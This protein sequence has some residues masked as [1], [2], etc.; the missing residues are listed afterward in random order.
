MGWWF[1][2]DD[3]VYDFLR[4]QAAK[5]VTNTE[6]IAWLT[7]FMDWLKRRVPDPR[8]GSLRVAGTRTHVHVV[9]D[10]PIPVAIV[11][12]M[13]PVHEIMY[14]LH[15]DDNVPRPRGRR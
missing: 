8:E 4:R 15:V 9:R 3:A 6:L 1:A 14:I 12:N 13:D 11:S 7:E 2:G 10:L 5:G